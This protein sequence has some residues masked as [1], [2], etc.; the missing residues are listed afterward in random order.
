MGVLANLTVNGLANL[1]NIS[2]VSISGGSNGQYLKTDGAGNLVWSTISNL[3][4]PGGSNTQLQFNADGFLGGIPNVT[5]NGSNLSLGNVA[6]VKMTGGSAG[7]FLQT[8]G[9]GNL[10]WSGVSGG[11]PNTGNITFYVSNISTNINNGDL[12]ILGNGLGNVNIRANKALNLSA[13]DL[14]NMEGGVTLEWLDEANNNGGTIGINEAGFANGVG[15]ISIFCQRNGFGSL[16]IFDASGNLAVPGNISGANVISANYFSGDGSNLSNISGS[17]ITN[18]P[19]PAFNIRSA[20][21]AAA[22]GSRYG[23]DTTGGAVVATLPAS[24]TTG[25]A[26]YFADAGGAFATNNLIIDPNGGTIMGSSGNMTISTDNQ[27]FGLFY[28]GTTW[29]TYNI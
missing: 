2:N 20:N 14:H 13:V 26:V 11:T 25:G 17:N 19:E 21:F 3:S 16:W 7:Y 15:N 8:D 22:Q 18:A 28:N 1:G 27:S 29:R 6:N 23:V 9:N 10:S 12:Q 24:P 5:W 4:I